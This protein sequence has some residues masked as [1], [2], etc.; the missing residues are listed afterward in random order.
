MGDVKNGNQ[1]KPPFALPK[2]LVNELVEHTV[3][4]FALF[5]FNP[6]TGYPQHVLSF[7]T[8]AHSLAMQKYMTDWCVAL[9]D[10]YVD[11]ARQQIIQTIEEPTDKEDDDE[12]DE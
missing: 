1:P 6:E 10:I 3:G 2:H 8:P 11:G 7:D 12:D 5:Y 9:Q 4:G